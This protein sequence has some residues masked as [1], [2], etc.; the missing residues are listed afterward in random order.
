M[1]ILGTTG[2]EDIARAFIA[3]MHPGKYVEFCE[4]VE[5]PIPRSDKWVLMISTM[6]GCPVGCQMC[7]AGGQ[8]GGNL[9]AEEILRQIDSHITRRFPDRRIDVAKFKIQFA[10]MGEPALNREVLDVLRYLPRGYDAP[11]LIPSV[12]SVAPSAGR[13]FFEELLEVKQDLYG[14]GRFQLQFSIHTTDEPLRDRL[15]P[16]DKWDLAAIADYG[17]AFY[18]RGDR[19]ITL[20]AALVEGMPLE[21]RVLLRHFDPDRFLLKI[22]PLNPTYRAK[23]HD[24][25]SCIDPSAGDGKHEIIE[26]LRMAGY[27]V[28]L[29]I[30]DPEENLIGSNCGQYVLRHL[31]ETESLDGAYTYGVVSD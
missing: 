4:S 25:T 7:D 6:F 9:S 30:G 16:V 3:E 22:T 2:R 31:R 23:E 17:E 1:R 28:L 5:P 26:D 11:G 29:S 14:G 27:E 18:R 24:L 12:S 8:Y 10:R 21:S 13:R 15:I 20:N 19:K